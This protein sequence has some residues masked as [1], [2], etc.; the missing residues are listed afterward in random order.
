MAD[1]T[2]SS[3][4]IDAAPDSVLEVIA[5]FE[6]YPAWTGAVKEVDV[7]TRTDDDRGSQVRF[8]LDAGAIRDTYVLQYSWDFAKDGTGTCPGNWSSRP[9]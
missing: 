2:V 4:V 5:D 3:I 6:S 9:C 7:L 8:V 1:R